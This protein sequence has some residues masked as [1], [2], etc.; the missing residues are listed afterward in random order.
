MVR[1]PRFDAAAFRQARVDAGYSRVELAAELGVTKQT[2]KSWEAGRR[3]PTSERLDTAA[4][5]LGVEPTM[6]NGRADSPRL[7]LQG[8]RETA[9]LSVRAAARRLGI[10]PK[11]LRR[12]E[13]GK[14]PPPDPARMRSV[15]HVED[16]VLDSAVERARQRPAEHR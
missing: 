11:T 2:V 16:R 7:D 6:L 10:D 15:Y 13:A 8:L 1:N 9:G 3:T 5:L 4:A 12:V 14:R